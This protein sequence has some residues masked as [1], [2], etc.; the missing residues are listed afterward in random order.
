MQTPPTN[1]SIK[2]PNAQSWIEKKK[3]KQ[4]GELKGVRY[5]GKIPDFHLIRLRALEI[6]VVLYF[7]S[8]VRK[9]N[10]GGLLI[11]ILFGKD[12]R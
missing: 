12:Q 11:T 7:F 3:K 10:N 6:A 8:V 5:P 1:T 4:F 9:L 2:L